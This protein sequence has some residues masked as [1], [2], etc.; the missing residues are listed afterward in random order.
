MGLEN[1]QEGLHILDLRICPL[2]IPHEVVYAHELLP[3]T[4]IDMTET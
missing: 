1:R 4:H 3:P 2:T